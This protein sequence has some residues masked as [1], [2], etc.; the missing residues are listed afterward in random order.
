MQHE[1]ILLA[2]DTIESIV[3][4]LETLEQ[5]QAEIIAAIRQD[6]EKYVDH[7]QRQAQILRDELIQQGLNND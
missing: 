6:L 1:D 4:S 3:G 7:L 2:Q 5:S